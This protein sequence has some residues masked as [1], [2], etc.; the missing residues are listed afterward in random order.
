MRENMNGMSIGGWFLICT[1]GSVNL[2]HEA[3]RR[4]ES[5]KLFKFMTAIPG[6]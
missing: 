4:N 6:R 2:A 1:G 3:D 5:M